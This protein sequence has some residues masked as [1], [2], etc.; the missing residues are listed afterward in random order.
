LKNKK[1]KK[2][3]LAV[4]TNRAPNKKVPEIAVHLAKTF[5]GSLYLLYVVT[6]SETGPAFYPHAPKEED[7]AEASR[8][9]E[10][11]ERKYGAEVKLFKK[12]MVVGNLVKTVLKKC[13]TLNPF[14]VVIGRVAESE[15]MLNLKIG[16]KQNLA[17]KVTHN[18]LL[19]K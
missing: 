13:K 4:C 15:I 17:R 6:S 2:T 7:V 8:F 5:G 3:I 16:V 14:L 11:F 12:E 19:V 18:L 10:S 9:L 1:E